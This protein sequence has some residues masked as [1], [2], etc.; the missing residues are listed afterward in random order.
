[1]SCSRV[2]RAAVKAEQEELERVLAASIA[3]ASPEGTTRK[4]GNPLA[5]FFPC[6]IIAI[7]I[8]D[9]IT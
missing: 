7:D 3:S 8:A 6:S 9:W 4:K 2:S 5:L 1:M